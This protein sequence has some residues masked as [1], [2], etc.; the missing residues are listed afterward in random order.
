MAEFVEEYSV[1]SK[2]W[3]NYTSYTVIALHILMLLFEDVPVGRT[4]FSLFCNIFYTFLSPAFPMIQLS[5]PTFIFSAI[6]VLSDHFLWFF[7]FTNFHN[8]KFLE[9]CAIFS[10]LIWLVPFLYFISLSASEY[11][12]PNF[13]PTASERSKQGK[14]GSAIKLFLNYFSGKKEELLLGS[15]SAKKM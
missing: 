1:I 13:S 2:R 11:T 12:L 8:F 6:L 14:F 3:I 10:I 15:G 9:I 7:F 4:L 5:D